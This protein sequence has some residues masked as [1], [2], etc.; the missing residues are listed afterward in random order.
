MAL[1]KSKL[2]LNLLRCCVRALDKSLRLSARLCSSKR[3]FKC[4]LVSPMYT[5]LD[6]LQGIAYMHPEHDSSLGW[7]KGVIEAGNVMLH[8]FCM[9]LTV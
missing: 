5:L 3:V 4:R 1:R 6:F 7:G 9:S 8:E 2:W